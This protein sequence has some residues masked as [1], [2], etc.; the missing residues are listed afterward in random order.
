VNGEFGGPSV[1]HEFDAP[2][3]VIGVAPPSE[4]DLSIVGDFAS[5]FVEENFAACIAEDCY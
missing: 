4:D 3:S 2:E 5:M 1:V